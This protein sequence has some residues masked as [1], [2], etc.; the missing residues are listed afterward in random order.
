MLSSLLL[1]SVQFVSLIP[2]PS[3]TASRSVYFTLQDRGG[4]TSLH[5]CQYVPSP[6]Q[7]DA[8]RNLFF[9]LCQQILLQLSNGILLKTE[10]C[11]IWIL[12][13]SLHF[14]PGLS[15]CLQ[16]LVFSL[17]R[18]NNINLCTGKHSKNARLDNT[19]TPNHPNKLPRSKSDVNVWK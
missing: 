15:D 12:N 2:P 16:I 14:F 11:S 5:H 8:S 17:R 7:W 19:A 3:K 18:R 6:H 9:N 13:L 4:T 1:S 10:C